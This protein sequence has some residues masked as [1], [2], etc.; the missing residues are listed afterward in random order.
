MNSLLEEKFQLFVNARDYRVG[1]SKPSSTDKPNRQ[2]ILQIDKGLQFTIPLIRRMNRMRLRPVEQ[3]ILANRVVKGGQNSKP[4]QEFKN[5]ILL[6]RDPSGIDKT[7]WLVKI[8][9]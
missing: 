4:Q 9:S 8:L 6:F 5:V 3:N 7:I 1:N 2:K